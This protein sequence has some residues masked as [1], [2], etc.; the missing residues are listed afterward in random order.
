MH[1]PHRGTGILKPIS[2]LK[3]QMV[4]R[5]CQERA[6]VAINTEKSANSDKY[7][8]CVNFVTIIRDTN[9]EIN[10]IGRDIETRI[11]DNFQF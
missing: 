11:L 4:K 1:Y 7:S 3:F 9:Y 6:T 8:R 2:P 5:R 10:V